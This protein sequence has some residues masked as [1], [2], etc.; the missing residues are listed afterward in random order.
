V[1]GESMVNEGAPAAEAPRDPADRH[2]RGGGPAILMTSADSDV[3]V[4]LLDV[5][6]RIVCVNDAWSRF[7]ADNGG[8]ATRCGVGVSYLEI[9]D[10]AADDGTAALV[11]ASVRSAL[12]GDL[13]APLAVDV[14]CHSSGELR[15]F[16]VLV[17]S[18]LGDDGACLG[19]TVTLSLARVVARAPSPVPT[20]PPDPAPAPTGWPR[21]ERCAELLG[22][23]V[24]HAVFAVAPCAVLLADDD[25]RIIAANAQ[26]DALFGAGAG[27]LISQRLDR[28][29]PSHWGQLSGEWPTGGEP[30]WTDA[31]YSGRVA[32]G[33]R[34]DGSF[35]R[36]QIASAPVP[37]SYGTGVLV[38]ASDPEVDPGHALAGTGAL[39]I[40]LDVVLRRVFSAGLTVA[41]VRE[42]LERDDVSARALT[43]AITDLDRAA[44]ELRHAA[45][46]E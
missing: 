20:L 2:A 8:D 27:G 43:D 5:E 24:A 40:D 25:G 31:A 18:R 42:R 29:L 19:A 21:G 7:C 6:G 30:R 44:S 26:A 11:A 38:T 46:H 34:L 37:L 10:R 33:A 39:L 9:C 1:R 16:D 12:Q 17:S 28:I 35:V 45:R 23:G 14:P 15:W 4:A 41:G 36:V 13:P 32:V 22:D 3:E